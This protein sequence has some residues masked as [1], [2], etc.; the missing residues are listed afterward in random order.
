MQD[1]NHWAADADSHTNSLYAPCSI[2]LR[3]GYDVFSE[4]S[5]HNGTPLDH[6]NIAA[7]SPICI[8]REGG[9]CQVCLICHSNGYLWAIWGND[10]TRRMTLVQIHDDATADPASRSH[11]NAAEYGRAPQ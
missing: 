9:A 11:T 2:V 5:Y 4:P 10:T 7:A 6:C 1:V 8:Q 3:G